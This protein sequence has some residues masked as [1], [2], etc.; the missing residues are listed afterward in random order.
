MLDNNNYKRRLTSC[1][2]SDFER[3]IRREKAKTE[4]DDDDDDDDYAKMNYAALTFLPSSN[5]LAIHPGCIALV[6]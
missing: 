5:F 3:F 4:D 6:R 2:E 1:I